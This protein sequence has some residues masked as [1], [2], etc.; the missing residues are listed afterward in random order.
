MPLTAF[1]KNFI[2]KN[3][4]KLSL[5]EIAGDLK[6][7]EKEIRKY[8][9]KH[10]PREKYEKIIQSSSRTEREPKNI[11]LESF[12]LK[13]F[14]IDNLNIF[15]LLFILVAISY[16]NSLG[17][18]FVSDDI[19]SILKNNQLGSFSNLSTYTVI[20]LWQALLAKFHFMNPT[21]FRVINI[22]FHLG[23]TYLVLLVTAMLSK[24]SVAIFCCCPFCGASP[25]Y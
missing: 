23:S 13:Q 9:K 7:S 3:I 20:G 5:P 2:K 11:D 25:S 6:I 1:Q 22:L 15:V 21:A 17:N 18:E 10:W 19:S 12:G 16:A 4:K 14:I 24:R 8:V